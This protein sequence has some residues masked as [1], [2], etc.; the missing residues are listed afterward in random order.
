MNN[1]NTHNG[2][3]FFLRRD[4]L[5]CVLLVITTLI[6]YWQVIHH[7]F[8]DFDDDLYITENYHVQNGL[9]IKGIYW[10]FTSTRGGNWHPITWLS[11]M[12]D[13]QLY[14]M[15]PGGH[16]L[17]S[18]LIHI[19]NTVLLFFV[20]RRM[21]G[22]LWRSGFM[23]ALFAVH[24]LHVESVAWVAERKD[25]LSIFFWML[26][27]WSY[28]RYVENPGAG[29]YFQVLLF[30]ILGLLSKSMIVTLPF[31]LLLLDYWPLCRFQFSRSGGAGADSQPPSFSL[32]LVW[33][34]IPLIVLAAAFS[35]VAFL[36][37]KSGGTVGSLE[38]YPIHYRIMNALVS[39]VS[40][41]GKMIWPFH[42]AFFY[43]YPGK[44]PWWHVSGAFLLLMSIS[45]L[46]IRNI[47]RFPWFAVGWL[48]YLGTLVPVIG[49]VQIGSQA[50]ADRYTYVP[51]IG[52][53]IMIAWAIPD[54]FKRWHYK[55]EGLVT[56]TAA[57]L[58]FFTV[59]TWFQVR[60]WENSVAL[61]E[62]ALDI[63][64]DNYLAHNNLGAVL[65]K[66][67]RVTE[68]IERYKEAL[69][70]EPDLIEAHNNLGVVLVNQGRIAEAIEHYT[71]ILGIKPNLAGTHNNLGKAY[72]AQ[73]RL[74]EAIPH[75]LEALRIDPNDTDV[76]INLGLALEAQG[77]VDAAI[78]QYREALRLA[79]NHADIHNNLGAALARKGSMAEAIRCFLSALN[80]DPDQADAHN[81]LGVVLAGQGKIDEAVY[82]F[83]NALQ[84][85]PGHSAARNNLKKISGVL[86]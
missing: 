56:I 24:P 22:D 72:E 38:I 2:T 53:F 71:Y 60:H 26:T 50:M 6:I 55:K 43:P 52:L 68:A 29:K 46:S 33:E 83:R 69:R 86:E 9:T 39:Y 47:R 76:S 64:T 81:N 30:F 41:I 4:V 49:L 1:I 79:P 11:H 80:L 35:A 42:L 5:V 27:L 73:G 13:I 25:V 51:L 66:Q 19:A 65:Q 34:K 70:I 7:E 40:Y 61:Y 23:A 75:Y 82:H 84:I 17:T 32:F 59:T 8:V 77:K 10:S 21:T 62:H 45:L 58:S 18:V 15:N 28:V 20:F 67:G 57:L 44:L 54:F 48:W 16:H 3:I 12:L 36:V 31:V 78:R 63:T 74:S 14:G 85:K 37:Q